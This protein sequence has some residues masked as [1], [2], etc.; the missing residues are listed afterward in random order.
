MVDLAKE[1]FSTNN[2]SLAAEIYERT[3]LENGP[4]SELF[5]G[6]ADSF[7]R[8]GNF[9]KAFESYKIAY[10]YGK[11][12]PEKLKHLVI[13]LVDTVKQDLLNIS[14]NKGKKSCMFICGVCRGL[15]ADPVTVPCGHTFC[16][17]C[18]EKDKSRTCEN[19]G[20]VHY[21]LKTRSCNS[22]VVLTNLIEKWFP[23]EQKAARLK[24]EGNEYFSKGDFVSAIDV[25]TRALAIAQ[26]DHLLLSNRSH[27]Y[28][29]LDRYEEALRDAEA[30]IK[31]RPDWPKGY[32][33]KGC[34]LFGLACY[35]EAAVAFLQCLALDQ[36]VASAKD[37]LSK[38]LDKILSALLPDDPK[39]EALQQRSN[40]TL[41]HK[42]IETNFTSPILLPDIAN[43]LCGLAQIVK[44]TINVASNFS[45]EPTPCVVNKEEEVHKVQPDISNVEEEPLSENL[46]WSSLPDCSSVD[47]AEIKQITKP[48]S[49]SPLLLA[50]RKRLRNATT[51]Q[52]PQHPASPIRSTPQKLLKST[53]ESSSAFDSDACQLK[54]EQKSVEDLEC[55]LCY[56]I[57]LEP[58]TT[59]CG[60]TFCRKCLDRC[61][62]HTVTCPLCKGN[63]AEYLAERRQSVTDSIQCIIETYFKAEYAERCRI[64]DEEMIELTKMGSGQQSDIPVFVC[65]LSFPTIPCPLHIFEPRYRL[66]IR[67]CMESG[68][69]QFGMCM[70]VN[71]PG[72]EFSDYGC[73]LEIR[74]VQYFPDGRSV[75][76]TIGGRRFK[77]LS[78]GKRDGYNT[79]KVEFLFDKPVREEDSQTVSALQAE[80]HTMVKN[81]LLKVP[82]GHRNKIMQ[83]FGELPD[84]DANA[85]FAPNGPAWLWWSVAVLPLDPRVQITMLAMCSLSERLIALKKVLEYLNRR[86]SQ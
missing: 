3:I 80:T 64:N 20:I 46:R 36:K 51:A 85:P 76:D 50:S 67:Q 1:A 73:M 60:H 5:L 8:A 63:L 14:G 84:Y 58:V 57:F 68:T 26:Q 21:R 25:Y 42:L 54:P 62:D 27:A 29:S 71:E 86:G 19:C 4:T 18:L 35:E 10:R 30:V 37:Y 16:R 56:R 22:N 12:T 2:F 13:G 47:H 48:R 83:H 23:N 70:H 15:L 72:K 17:K 53:L 34:A 52:H 61:L 74:D 6:L 41:L 39:A 45:T 55:G 66:M 77:V 49:H 78:R 69:R 31:I 28:S 7:A 44:E 79:A 81:W 43:T 9:S 38:A 11:V 75:V 33:R 82:A 65:T 24:Q 32:F 40:P 59:P